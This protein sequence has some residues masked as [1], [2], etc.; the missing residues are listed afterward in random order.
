LT[1][2]HDRRAFLRRLAALGIAAPTVSTFGCSLEDIRREA[3]SGGT[4]APTL[5]RPVLLPWTD[6]AVRISAPLSKYPA[7]Y[8][9][10]PLRKAY[11]DLE[12]RLETRMVLAAHIS[13][14]TG[15]WRIPLPGD[16]LAIPV[17]A[18][19]EL[20][21]FEERPIGEWNPAMDP[22]EGDFR[23]QRGRRESV[24]IAFDCLP[25]AEREGW[26]S[27]GPWDVAQCVAGP[28]T[29]LCREIF[30]DVGIGSHYSGRPFGACAEPTGTVRYVVWTAPDS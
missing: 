20:R 8:I 18:G 17:D 27:G 30:T 7:A 2:R 23:V 12:S 13:V 21:E 22:A 28:G 19:D 26:F 1:D 16:N 4:E 24:R 5:T 14:S 25:M 6:G 10:R 9:S 11:I 3:E 29:E 15:H